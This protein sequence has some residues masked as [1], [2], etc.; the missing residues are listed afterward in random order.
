MDSQLTLVAPGDR[1][2]ASGNLVIVGNQFGIRINKTNL[3][4]HY[5]KAKLASH[6]LDDAR[7][8]PQSMPQ[9]SRS[10][11]RPQARPEVLP[12]FEHDNLDQ[13]LEDIGIDPK[14]L[15]ELE[16]LY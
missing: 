11:A 1:P 8:N 4:G 15:D 16:D 12:Q 3:K 9:L 13:E 5:P 10:Q 2:I 7:S 14:E 6:A